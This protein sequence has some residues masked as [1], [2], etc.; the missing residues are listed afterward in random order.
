M[1]HYFFSFERYFAFIYASD[2]QKHVGGQ[3][4]A[5]SQSQSFDTHTVCDP[6]LPEVELED[7]KGV[8]A[9]YKVKPGTI[10]V[11]RH[12][13]RH[14]KPHWFKVDPIYVGSLRPVR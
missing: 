11:Q 5:R 1:I 4:M 6:T 12:L 9:I 14:G 10:R 2:S 7:D 13:R 8:A 3:A